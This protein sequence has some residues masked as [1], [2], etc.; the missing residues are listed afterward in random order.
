[1]YSTYLQGVLGKLEGV[2]SPLCSLQ[3]LQADEATE[4][5]MT[6][7]RTNVRHFLKHLDTFDNKTIV[8]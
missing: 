8:N 2:A 4:G 5:E 3:A 7:K 6:I 1:M